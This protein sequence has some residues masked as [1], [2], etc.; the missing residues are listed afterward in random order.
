[1]LVS[2]LFWLVSVLE[3][4]CAVHHTQVPTVYEI[5][6]NATELSMYTLY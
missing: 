3:T 5:V 4:R 1:M 2:A 6:E